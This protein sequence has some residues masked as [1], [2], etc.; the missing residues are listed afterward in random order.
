M[1]GISGNVTANFT[2][3]GTGTAL[4]YAIIAGQVSNTDIKVEN[5]GVA[6]FDAAAFIDSTLFLGQGTFAFGGAGGTLTANQ[7]VGWF[8]ITGTSD[9]FANSDVAAYNVG[10]VILA[11]V[12]TND[13]GTAFGIEAQKSIVEV[14]VTS[15][16]FTWKST[17]PAVQ[18]DGDFEV[19]LL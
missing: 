1:L 10:A 6:Y 14:H 3:T 11:S 16:A 7:R 15:P 4:G 12:Q 8:I 9:A 13:N 19:D 17:G 2:L 5:G 18:K